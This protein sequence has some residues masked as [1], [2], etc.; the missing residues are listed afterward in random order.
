M[1]GQKALTAESAA[2]L[3]PPALCGPICVPSQDDVFPYGGSM[4]VRLPER[5]WETLRY[6]LLSALVMRNDAVAE[7][8]T[9]HGG[10]PSDMELLARLWRSLGDSWPLNVLQ[11][12]TW[13]EAAICP[14]ARFIL[15]VAFAADSAADFAAVSCS[16][17]G[18]DFAAAA[19]EAAKELLSDGPGLDLA[20]CSGWP[21]FAVLRLLGGILSHSCGQTDEKLDKQRGA[22]VM[23]LDWTDDIVKDA[24]AAAVASALQRCLDSSSRKASSTSAQANVAHEAE[25]IRLAA[26]LAQA[27]AALEA[28]QSTQDKAFL[29]RGVCPRRSI[30]VL[31]DQQRPLATFPMC[32]R[33]EYNTVDDEL[34]KKGAWTECTVLW[35]ILKQ[36]GAGPGCTVVDAGANI[37]ACT[38]T[39]AKLGLRVIAVE[40][41][42]RNADLMEASLRLNHI[43]PAHRLD[44]IRGPDA[45]RAGTAA[46]LRMALG[47][48]R[49]IGTITERR[50]NAGDS[51]VYADGQHAAC[52]NA[53]VACRSER[54][55]IERL[56]DLLFHSHS[57]SAGWTVCLLKVDVQGAEL[58][59]LE[60]A[61]SLLRRR[62]VGIVFFEWRPEIAELAGR[63]P[64]APLRLLA[65]FGYRVHAPRHWFDFDPVQHKWV[66]VLE[67]RFEVLL[68]HKGNILATVG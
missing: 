14:P 55:A 1:D 57:D 32:V 25:G 31:L 51:R 39:L 54:V 24:P 20:F 10:G 27:D 13:S 5:P 16:E 22:R 40:P 15:R 41:L 38:V 48:K 53:T 62:L 66:Q 58:E 30:G 35:S 12:I 17:S 8:S 61:R 33:A 52:D 23:P 7:A 49:G 63:D 18:G 37:G 28:L 11:Q 4:Y 21:V 6:Q 9:D 45:M 65:A 68:A 46:V 43:D 67:D 36:F 34:R 44:S 2:V 50:N 47:A 3:T 59:V 29:G 64:L 60:G 42:P 56:D 19:V 26:C